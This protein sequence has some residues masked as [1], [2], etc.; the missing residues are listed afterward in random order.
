MNGGERRTTDLLL[1]RWRRSVALLAL[2]F[3]QSAEEEVE[4]NVEIPNAQREVI[5]K[6][7][8]ARDEGER[9]TKKAPGK[10]GRKEGRKGTEFRAFTLAS[11]NASIKGERY[12]IAFPIYFFPI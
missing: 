2:V 7:I 11:V 3:S 9:S 12:A 4:T 10:E 1:H 8:R 5:K 6:S